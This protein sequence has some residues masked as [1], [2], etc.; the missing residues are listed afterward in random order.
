MLLQLLLAPQGSCPA[1]VRSPR[2]RGLPILGP[3]APR[4]GQSIPSTLAH[5][6]R[7]FPGFTRRV[8]R[9]V[10]SLL[11]VRSR[12]RSPSSPTQPSPTPAVPPPNV[13]AEV[14]HHATTC[15]VGGGSR[16][17]QDAVATPLSGLIGY[18]TPQLGPPWIVVIAIPA[19]PGPGLVGLRSLAFRRRSRTS[20][21]DHH[22][23]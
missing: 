9:R 17:R 19:A 16:Q 3:V 18:A 8:S 10:Y 23:V 2:P 11:R 6:R 12:P 4:T 1:R 21:G 15:L 13:G 14:A 7:P 22:I 20:T 5:R